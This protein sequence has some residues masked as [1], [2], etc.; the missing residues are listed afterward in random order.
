MHAI[1]IYL[2]VIT[3]ACFFLTV[4][5]PA[6]YSQPFSSFKLRKKETIQI[7]E[8]Q[9]VFEKGTLEVPEDRTNANARNILL[10]MQIIRASIPNAPEP[11]FWLDGSSVLKNMAHTDILLNVMKSLDFLYQYFDFNNV[12]E[13]LIKPIERIDFN[14]G[15]SMSKMKIFIAGLLL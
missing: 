1:K 6:S 3:V 7:D 2:H 8:K 15:G 4:V 5:I 12:D 9:Y 14:A 11:I 10:P 13:S